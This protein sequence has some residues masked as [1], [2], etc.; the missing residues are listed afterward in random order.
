MSARD[1]ARFGLLYLR[2]G[3]WDGTQIVSQEWIREST[4]PHSKFEDGRGYGYLWWTAEPQ[5]FSPGSAL[6]HHCFFASGFGE[7][8]LIMIPRLDLV[9]VH[10]VAKVDYGISNEQ[11][12]Q[13]LDLIVASRGD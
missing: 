12:G 8:Y 6:Q 9:V 7:Q 13:L 3:K 1:L 11:M 4:T 5:S 2:E 10:V